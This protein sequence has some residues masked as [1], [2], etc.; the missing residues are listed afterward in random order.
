VLGGL[1]AHQGVLSPL[2]SQGRR[3][4]RARRRHRR[5][6]SRL[7]LL[8][9]EGSVW[10]AGEVGE[11]RANSMAG[12]VLC[13]RGSGGQTAEGSS[14]RAGGYSGE[15]SRAGKCETGEIRARLEQL[16]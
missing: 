13:E 15:Q 7:G 16:P 2:R 5:R 11:G 9:R 14:R 6:R 10:V 1:D 8:G 4:P 12:S 3:S